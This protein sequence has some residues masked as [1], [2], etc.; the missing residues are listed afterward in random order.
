M[1]INNIGKLLRK[2]KIENNWSQQELADKIPISRESIS[3]WEKS[4]NIPDYQSLIRISEIF[5]ISVDEID[6]IIENLFLDIEFEGENK[7]VKL[8]LEEEFSNDNLF[9]KKEHSI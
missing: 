5:N 7:V 9:F 2:L 3:K 1:D 6:Y 4:K 8:E